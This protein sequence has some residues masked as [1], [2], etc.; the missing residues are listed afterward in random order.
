[1]YL[2]ILEKYIKED[3]GIRLLLSDGTE[4]CKSTGLKFKKIN[5]NLFSM[6]T[7]GDEVIHKYT[8][9]LNQIHLIVEH[10]GKRKKDLDI[11]I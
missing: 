10:F 3:V 1:M 8:L 5:D 7:V 9:N 2:S 11:Y 4:I 6:E